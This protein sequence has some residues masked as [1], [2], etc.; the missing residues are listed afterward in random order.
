[1]KFKRLLVLLITLISSLS[2]QAQL[3]V[4]FSH[5]INGSLWGVYPWV[6]FN[7][8]SSGGGVLTQWNW[9]FGGSRVSTHKWQNTAQVAYT[10]PGTYNVCLN[11]T[12]TLSNQASYCDSVTVPC[13]SKFTSTINSPS[14]QFNN[15]SFISG[16]DY[17]WN[18]GDG[19]PLNTGKSPLH[20]YIQGGRFN[21]CLTVTDSL[22]NCTS[23]YCD[24]VEVLGTS[25]CSASFSYNMVGPTSI[26]FINTSSNGTG[27]AYVMDFG[28]GRSQ[29]I[30]GN[31]N[32]HYYSSG[33]YNVCLTVLD[34]SNWC[35]ASYCD[36]IIVNGQW[37]Q[38]SIYG[39]IYYTDSLDHDSLRIY[40]I[41]EDPTFSTPYLVAVDSMDTFNYFQFQQV[42]TGRYYVKAAI[43]SGEPNHY[44]YFPTYFDNELL[45]SNADQLHLSNSN[46]YPF[47]WLR[48]GTN[49][50]GPGFI[51]GF[52]SMG[53]NLLPG[54][55]IPNVP[56]LLMNNLDEPVQHTVTDG[57]GDYGF[58][59]LAY[60]TYKIYT[61]ILN[62]L[63][64]PVVVSI[65]PGNPSI[66]NIKIEV[67]S[68]G[69][70]GGPVE[71]GI[72][73]YLSDEGFRIFPNPTSGRLKIQTDNHNGHVNI[74]DQTG[75]LI[76]S[77]EIK[78]HS[79][80]VIVLPRSTEN[81]MYIV[82]FNSGKKTY[83]QL[84]KV[85]K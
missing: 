82:R 4:S 69:S 28:D 22:T 83:R 62:V 13:I 78:S 14:V 19:S 11:V 74:Y 27:A 70:S 43:L 58:S 33:S 84:L 60:G 17:S 21:V 41:K 9:N 57:N 29:R 55:P 26:D 38:W 56:I 3:T 20:T 52:V 32:H 6:Y 31:V 24:T 54:D 66:D 46:Q 48:A 34:S 10:Y 30:F 7:V 59:N 35:S 77:E 71:T 42:D 8:S 23:T 76:H 49:L 85:E 53:A 80:P 16:S 25:P 5:N 79:D 36:T 44:N 81:G 50:G 1:M 67:N 39:K 75:K 2:I 12:D 45:W 61:D 73:N 64:D 68:T 47:Y 15:Y 51:G 37:H 40:L 72:S 63:S 65:G 18:F